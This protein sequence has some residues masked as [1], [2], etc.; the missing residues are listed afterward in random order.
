MAKYLVVIEGF[1]PSP[2]PTTPS[3]AELLQ[4]VREAQFASDVGG[5]I[6]SSTAPNVV[7]YPILA[8]FRWVKTDVSLVP[9][10]EFYYH[11][12]S[13]WVIEKPAV[14]SITGSML[15]DGLS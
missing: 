6:L 12:G 4:M 8:R 15:V 14:G 10:G 13:S 2:L 5:L 11:D 7:Q 3:N 9:I 1:D